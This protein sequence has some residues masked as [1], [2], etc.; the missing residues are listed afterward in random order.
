[1]MP[2]VV[3][4]PLEPLA[5]R[6]FAPF[7]E[8]IGVGEGP[9][10]FAGPHIESWAMRFACEDRVALMYARYVH[11]PME[12]SCLETHRHVSQCF[13]PLGYCPSVMVV[14]PPAARSRNPRP[15]APESVRA[16][17][18]PGDRGIVLW[19]RTWHAQTRFPVPP[20]GGAFALLTSVET[21]RELERERRDGTP[22]TLTRVVDYA[23][24]MGVAFRVVDTQDLLTGASPRGCVPDA[25]V[26]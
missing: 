6:A 1:M 5:G 3:D 9:P 13:I 14:A 10:V 25:D 19:R 16:F 12:F 8:I 23:G 26:P 21:Q 15:P 17:L 2:R 24:E 4:L 20:T 7:G 18:V 11:Q 22:P